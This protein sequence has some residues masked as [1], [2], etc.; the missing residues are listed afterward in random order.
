MGAHSALNMTPTSRPHA[1]GRKLRVLIV[2]DESLISLYLQDVLRDLGHCVSAVAPSFRTALAAAAGTP[3]DL[4]IVDVG[5]V[6]DGGDGIDAAAALLQRHGVPSVLMTGESFAGL[7]E[8]IKSARPLAFLMKPC[9]QADVEH[10]LA[11][12]LEHLD[13]LGATPSL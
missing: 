13:E 10:A 6:G 5:L 2:E 8:R 9:T 12:A 11:T 1:A 3:S 4:A 7:D